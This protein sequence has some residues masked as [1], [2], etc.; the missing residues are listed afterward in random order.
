MSLPGASAWTVL[1]TPGHTDDSIALW[2]ED[3]RTL[4]SGDAV[5]SISGQPRFAPDTVDDNAAART[6]AKLRALP[7]EHLLS[8]HG[9]PIHTTAMWVTSR[10]W[11]VEADESDP[12]RHGIA[13]V[14]HGVTGGRREAKVANRVA[15]AVA[16]VAAR[17][18]SVLGPRS[19][20]IVARFNRYV[21]NPAVQKLLAPHLRHM[22]VI[23]HCGRRSGKSYQTPVMAFVEDGSVSVVL[24]YG[25]ESDWVRN[26][27]AAGSAVVVHQ[28][29]RYTL[30]A[31]RVLSIDSP[32]LPVGM[33]AVGGAQRNALHATLTPA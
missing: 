8:G 7:V 15:H 5:I 16:R 4:L 17:T 31:P 14:I 12:Y 23:E 28:G 25:A 9:L 30:S 20:R 26:V 27:V 10:E 11:C 22:V 21:T 24:N 29:K 13:G 33:R 18:A 2:N 3:S 19:M 6:E 32:E 1:T